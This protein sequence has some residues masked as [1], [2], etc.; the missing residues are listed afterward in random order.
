MLPDPF[1]PIKI[2]YFRPV[3]DPALIQN[4]DPHFHIFTSQLLYSL[5]HFVFPR[6]GEYKDV[7][8]ITSL[9]WRGGEMPLNAPVAWVDA[10]VSFEGGKKMFWAT[11]RARPKLFFVPGHP[12]PFLQGAI[13]EHFVLFFPEVGW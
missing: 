13:W 12:K 11:P 1:R 7:I 10:V 4:V 9:L 5:C 3:P 8:M 6:T 2:C